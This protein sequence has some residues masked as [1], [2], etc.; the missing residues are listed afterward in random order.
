MTFGL[1]PLI[2]FLLDWALRLALAV[3]IIMRRRAVTASLAWLA[4]LV[5]VPLIGLVLYLLI[6]ETRLGRRRLR[7]FDRLSRL[8]ATETVALWRKEHAATDEFDQA[9]GHIARFGTAVTSLPPLRG[10]RLSL[11]N[12]SEQMLRSLAEDIDRATRHVHI[13]TY[14]WMVGGV[15]QTIVDAL[16]RA[17]RRGVQCRVLVDAVG[18]KAFLRSGACANLRVAGVGVVASLPVNPLRMIFAR[19]DLRNHRKIAVIDGSIAYT[20][21]QNLTDSTF[22]SNALRQTGPWIDATLRIEGPA[23]QALAIVFLRDW[24]LDSNEVIEDLGPFL[25]EFPV[26]EDHPGS[27]I[28]IMPSGPGSSP[29]AIHQALLTTIYAAREELLMTTPYFVPDDATRTALQ[30]AAMRGVA[31]TLVMPRLSDSPLVAAASRSHYLDLL[32]SGV[33]IMHYHGGLLHAKTVSVDR[34][35]AL[36]GSANFDARS[37]WLNFEITAFI[38]DNDFASMVRFMQTDYLNKSTEVSLSHWRSRPVWN[39]FVDN[40]AQLFGP[41]L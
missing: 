23:A 6:G 11:L 8:L 12:D 25:P 7:E 9:W 22:R 17:S 27:I 10:N 4:V 1:T 20:G 41:L 18:S 16:I 40:T 28:Q 2:I 19:I 36:I 30:A 32:E 26:R 35:I 13:L 5:F 15:P 39:V 31:V 24:L 34:H 37:F 14:I 29:Q 21:S 3:H 33:K 38:F